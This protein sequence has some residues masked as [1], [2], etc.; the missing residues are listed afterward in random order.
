MIKREEQIAFLD[1]LA[2]RKMNPSDLGIQLA[3][4]RHASVCLHASDRTDLDRDGLSD[5]GVYGHRDALLSRSILGLAL[6]GFP[7]GAGAEAEHGQEL[8]ATYLRYLRNDV[9]VT[10]ECYE[11]LAARYSGA[12]RHA[13]R[14]RHQ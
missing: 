6:V 8:D 7:V 2:F 13:R 1:G 10:W 9:Q 14:H 11:R 3:L 4:E 5:C 12:E